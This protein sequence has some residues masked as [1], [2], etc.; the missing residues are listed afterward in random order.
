MNGCFDG[1]IE[2]PGFASSAAEVV[3]WRVSTAW[4]IWW[5]AAGW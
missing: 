3:F 1:G 5:T 2:T 4:R